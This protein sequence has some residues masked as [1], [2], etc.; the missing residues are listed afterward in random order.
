MADRPL[1]PADGRPDLQA[2]IDAARASIAREARKTRLRMGW[3]RLTRALW[4]LGALAAAFLGLALL[5]LPQA[6]PTAL[7]WLLLLAFA[8]AAG[9]LVRGAVRGWRT[10]TLAEAEARLDENA[11]DRPVEAVRDALAQGAADAAAR[12]VWLTHQGRLASRAAKARAPQADLRVSGQDRFA[13]RHAALIALAAGVIASLGDGG[14]ALTDALTPAGPAPAAAAAPTVTLE[15]W[16]SPPAYTGRAPVYLTDRAGEGAPIALPTGAEIT[17]RVF[18]A[19]AAPTLTQSLGADAAAFEAAGP[20]SWAA[21]FV[22]TESGEMTVGLPGAAPA[23]WA[24]TAEPDAGPRIAF[25]EAPTATRG[26]ALRFGFEASDD[27]GVVAALATVTLDAGA[28]G[29]RGLPADTVFEPV[30]FDLPLSLRGAAE[31]ASE[32]VTRDLTEHPWAGLPV[33]VTLTAEDGAGQTAAATASMTLPEKRFR[34][35]LARAIIEQR[36]ELAWSV[37]AAPRILRVLDAVTA[38]PDDAFDDASAYL[39]VR[40]ARRRLGYAVDEARLTDETPG[41]AELL[42]RAALT[43]EHGDLSD[44]ERRL[45]ELQQEL[46]EALENGA[47]DDEIAQLMDELREALREFMQQMAEEALRNQAE[48]GQQPQQPMDPGQMMSQQDLMDM[49]DQ[50]EQAMRDGMQDMARQMLEQLQQMLENLQMAQPGQPGQQGQQGGPMQEL[51]DMI[52]QQQGLADRSFDALREGQQQGEGQQ[53][54]Q[55]QQP[56]QGQGDQPGQGQGQAQGQPGGRGEGRGQPGGPDLGAIARDQES[57]RRMLDDLRR[58]LPGGGGDAGEALERAER[59][60]GQARDALG[61]GDADGALQD[62]V[63]ALDALREGAQDLAQQMQNQPGQAQQAGRAGQ[64][65]DVRD[66]DP[67]GRPT[68]TDGPM[69]GDSVAVPDAGAMKRARE[70]MDEIRRRAGDQTRSPLEL[71]YLRRLLERF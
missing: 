41:V 51:Q 59:S 8:G 10:P 23:A 18:D 67:F 60:M 33:T 39:M 16:A 71:D 55:G 6:L 1:D 58:G 29:P 14:G 48:N 52:G 5:G 24:F 53:G 32:I 13:L 64:S 46:S 61:G 63:E 65:G 50:L 28:A 9:W 35:P 70:L 54:Q 19:D 69:D 57:L 17:L 36:R 49:L 22:M 43:I 21:G 15:A 12:E 11:P 3:E 56:G 34:E 45:R 2:R 42:W 20:G 62:Q 37:A 27:F 47:G 30:V 66:E 26:G 7:H 25:T 40:T 31:S 68:A 4:P 44:A 38:H